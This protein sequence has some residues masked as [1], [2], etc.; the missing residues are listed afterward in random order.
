MATIFITGTDTGVGK[1]HAACALIH[2]LRR[3]GLTICGFKPVASGCEMTADGLRNDDA[4]ALQAAAGTKERY[5][6]I[7]P[8]AYA[9]AI[10][11]H[12]AAAQAG[13]PV[14][15]DLLDAAYA[16]LAAR[17]ERVI[18][19]GAGGW[20]VPLDERMTFADW[21]GAH[22][23]PVV[24]VVGLRLGCINHALLSAD[25]I[26]R[27]TQLVGWIA[28]QLPPLQPEWQGSLSSLERRMSAPL[29]GCL[30]EGLAPAQAAAGLDLSAPGFARSARL[31]L[32]SAS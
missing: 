9:P 21:V 19:E 32:Q 15:R 1:T 22:E 20:L 2:A 18:V 30:P 13:R 3:Q 28:N 16:R 23:W 8:C 29:L 6:Q 24:L 31:P 5:D 17:Y 14:D 12:L 27:R 10:A 7:N 25:A 26:S 4:L 11:P